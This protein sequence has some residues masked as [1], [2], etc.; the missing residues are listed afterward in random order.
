MTHTYS[1]WEKLPHGFNPIA[2]SF[3]QLSLLKEGTFG[4]IQHEVKG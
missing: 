2:N 1:I 3:I 4:W